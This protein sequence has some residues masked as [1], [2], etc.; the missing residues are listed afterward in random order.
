MEI[1]F[2]KLVLAKIAALTY[3]QYPNKFNLDRRIT[4][5]K[6]ELIQQQPTGKTRTIY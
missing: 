6:N 2:K 5:I 1:N 3:N 4:N